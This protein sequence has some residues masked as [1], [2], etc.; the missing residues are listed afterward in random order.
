MKNPNHILVIEDNPGDFT[1]IEEFIIESI[2]RPEITHA[3]NFKQACSLLSDPSYSFDVILLDLSLPDKDGNELIEEMLVLA[4]QIPVII[5]TGYSNIDFAAKAISQG[6]DDYLLKDE[7]TATLL[8]KSITYS[9]E[10]KKSNAALK[11]SEKRYSNLFHFSPQP[12]WVYDT[13]TFRFVEVNNAAVAKY[14]FSEEEFL[15]MT[16]FDIRPKEDADR[17]KSIVDEI[18]KVNQ[19]FYTGKFRHL[20]KEGQIFEVEIYS[21]PIS[22]DKPSLRS[23]IA[24]DITE[25]TLYEQLITQAIIKTQE[26]ERYEIGSELHDNICQILAMTQ[27]NL[28]KLKESLSI[29]KMP[30]YDNAKNTLV[31]ALEEIRS[32]SH[33]LA[34]A[35]YNELTLEESFRKLLKTFNA[36]KK[37]KITFDFQD[38]LK[39]KSR[40]QEMQLNL[41]RILQEQL[42]N[43]DKYAQATEIKIFLFIKK[44]NLYMTTVDNGVGFVMDPE[45]HGI[46]F[47]N[48]QRR[49]EFFKGDIEINTAPGQGC[50]IT[51]TIPLD[52]N[53]KE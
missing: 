51:I 31:L 33:R 40:Y 3:E 9:I 35:F 10:R 11:E 27:M 34:P 38:E 46:G 21:S 44:D 18:R 23:V 2:D 29:E 28:D 30:W 47:A 25:K 7:L 12:M 8:I 20:N 4:H 45:K 1:I 32:L 26:E 36:A 53:P 15:K 22:I 48:M 6:I 5:L 19:D 52:Q 37:Y 17:V 41:Y 13:A 16:I 39:D 43:I 50:K 24:Y 14:G 42:R 49:V